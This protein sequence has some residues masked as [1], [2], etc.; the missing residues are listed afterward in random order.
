MFALFA[1]ALSLIAFGAFGV[2]FLLKMRSLRCESFA[3]DSLLSVD[4]Y[5]PMLRLLSND[6]LAFV[7]ADGKLKRKLRA[8]RRELFRSYLRCLT[9]DY[10]RLLAGV[11]H[12]M[13][14]SEI[15]RPE[16]ARALAKNRMLF[17]LA[18]CKVEFRLTLHAVGADGV[19][20]SGLVD[21]LEALRSQVRVLS[22]LPSMA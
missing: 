18:V 5:R 3:P 7:A 2:Q 19:D 12:V 22:A 4:R 13:V 20:I 16:L 9:R 6:D 10:A 17:A 8:K 15:D 14:Q 11:R 21:G 1:A